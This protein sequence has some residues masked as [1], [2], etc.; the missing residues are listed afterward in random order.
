MHYA[1]DCD[2][3]DRKAARA[4]LLSLFFGWAALPIA[5][6]Y[7]VAHVWKDAG[8]PKPRM[9]KLLRGPVDRDVGTLSI[10]EDKAKVKRDAR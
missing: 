9:P 10:V 8:L 3:H 4:L 5:L 7:I 1:I 6:C 2:F